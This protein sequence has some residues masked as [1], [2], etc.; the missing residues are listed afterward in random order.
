MKAKTLSPVICDYC[1]CEA[2]L[3]GGKE[4]YPYRPDLF[5]LQFWKCTPCDAWVGCHRSSN[6]VA[7][8]RLA[9]SELR[10]AKSLAHKAFDPTWKSGAM[11]LKAAYRWLSEKMGVS[12]SDCHIGMFDVLQ[13]REVVRLCVTRGLGQVKDK[14]SDN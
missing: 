9:N 2:A 5:H 1:G 6:A 14:N 7:L 4:I 13:C 11:S 8:G 10:D 12:F 3:V